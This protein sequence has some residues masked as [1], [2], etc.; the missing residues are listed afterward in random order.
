[1][2]EMRIDSKEVGINQKRSISISRMKNSLRKMSS[3]KVN[4]MVALTPTCGSDSITIRKNL[5]KFITLKVS[6]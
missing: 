4:E 3:L 2:R 6:K 5:I 1:M